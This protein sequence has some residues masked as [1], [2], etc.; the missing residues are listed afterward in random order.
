MSEFNR[1]IKGGT[2]AT[3][4]DTFAADIGIKNGRITALGEN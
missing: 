1:V 2:I 4:S 3:A